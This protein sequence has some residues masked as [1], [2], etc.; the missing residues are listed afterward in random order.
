MRRIGRR[1]LERVRGGRSEIRCC[2]RKTCGIS[3]RFA[4][5]RPFGK[6]LRYAARMLR[7]S[8]GPTA[9][10]FCR[11]AIGIGANTAIFSV[12]DAILLEVAA[13]AESGGAAG[14]IE[15]GGAGCSHGHIPRL[16]HQEQVWHPCY[17]LISLSNVRAVRG[18]CS[19][20]SDL[21]GLCLTGV[22]V[23]A[24]A[25]SHYADEE[26]VTGNFFTGLGV[27]A[28]AGQTRSKRKTTTRARHR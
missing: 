28:L 24:G 25:E 5:S 17:Q 6:D 21:M 26:L 18:Q 1:V 13:G 2:S 23:M 10:A 7:R 11:S 20:V 3:G 14:D 9:V 27:T 16:F 8:P 22:T 4:W 15:D 12:V 19:A